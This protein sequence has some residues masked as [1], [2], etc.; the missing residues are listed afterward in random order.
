MSAVSRSAAFRPA[1]PSFSADS[2]PCTH[3][4]LRSQLESFASLGLA[5]VQGAK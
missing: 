5:P 2:M 4:Q 3:R 1:A